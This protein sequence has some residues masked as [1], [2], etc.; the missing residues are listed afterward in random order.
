MH[1][2][3]QSTSQCTSIA[4]FAPRRNPLSGLAA[5][6]V[7]TAVLVID[8]CTSVTGPHIPAP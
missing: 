7:H 4:S 1:G 3:E 8:L 2:G 6:S 5:S